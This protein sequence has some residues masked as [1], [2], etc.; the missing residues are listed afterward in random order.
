MG[1]A[2][3]YRAC[4]S[5]T[6]DLYEG[7]KIKGTDLFL[8]ARKFSDR[9]KS[10][11]KACLALL[12]FMKPA[13]LK[14]FKA[15]RSD[16]T[17][18]SEIWA[19]ID[20]WC[21]HNY[22]HSDFVKIATGEITPKNEWERMMY[23]VEWLKYD[24]YMQEVIE[25]KTIENTRPEIEEAVVP[26][27]TPEQAMQKL[28]EAGLWVEPHQTETAQKDE[29]FKVEKE[30]EQI[31]KPEQSEQIEPKQSE[32]ID[33]G[34]K[35]KTKGLQ[36]KIFDDIN[37]I[38]TG[39]DTPQ[40]NPQHDKWGVATPVK[41]TTNVKRNNGNPT[42]QPNL[43]NKKSSSKKNKLSGLSAIQ[44]KLQ[45]TI[46]LIPS[47]PTIH[48]CKSG[49]VL[50]IERVEIPNAAESG[51]TGPKYYM[52]C[53]PKDISKLYK[54]TG[55]IFGVST[56]AQSGKTYSTNTQLLVPNN[57]T[58]V[59]GQALYV[60]AGTEI[61]SDYT[62]SVRGGMREKVGAQ[63]YQLIH[64][65][66]DIDENGIARLR[67]PL[68]IKNTANFTIS[69]WNCGSNARKALRLIDIDTTK[70]TLKVPKLK[71]IGI[72]LSDIGADLNSFVEIH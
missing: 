7:R 52:D 65:Y 29:K 35:P 55:L 15:H 27:D 44:S 42:E 64:R 25:G 33:S 5:F 43:I 30:P 62:S 32:G 66:A 28:K 46:D 49:E 11:D 37:A 9:F 63:D 8:Y 2:M 12:S 70:C 1:N 58:G 48:V 20:N 14:D 69:L 31:E 38:V 54:E 60:L 72:T 41:K 40:E 4:S 68:L 18:S 56:T 24:L 57:S 53:I 34:Q 71:L 47:E 59:N 26:D 10:N 39:T 36:D 21:H 67:Y 51:L 3:D 17:T 19:V 45:S 22:T 61:G 16:I 6:G 50:V 13:D 23:E